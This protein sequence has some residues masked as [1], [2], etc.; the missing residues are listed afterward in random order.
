MSL[1]IHNN[2][3]LKDRRR[4]LRKR[5]TKEEE[6]L[7]LKIRNNKLGYKFKRQHSIGGYILDFYCSEARLIIEIDGASHNTKEAREYDKI[8]DEYFSEL[9]YTTIRFLNEEIK[10]KME[11]VV[12]KIKKYLIKN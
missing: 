9:G 10:N 11:K 4:E 3:K 5:S 2:E 7:W 8:R 12:N 6:M 1:L